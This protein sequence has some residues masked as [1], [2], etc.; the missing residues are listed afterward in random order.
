M[1]KVCGRG[2]T[3]CVPHSEQVMYMRLVQ[4]LASYWHWVQVTQRLGL[5]T[6]SLDEA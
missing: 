3:G 1:V 6:L 2:Y 5:C 4:S